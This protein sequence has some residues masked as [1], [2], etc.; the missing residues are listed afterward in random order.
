M[1]AKVRIGIDVGGTFT[2]AV[3]IDNTTH[4]ILAKTKI[5][6]THHEEKGVAAGI[7]RAIEKVLSENRIDPEDVVFIAHGTTQATNALLEG[8]VARV[9][10]IGMGKG[11]G[12]EGM[13]AQKETQIG[14]IELAP[15]KLLHTSQTFLDSGVCTDEDI[16]AAVETVKQAG[17]EVVVASEAYSVDDPA[18]EQRVIDIAVEHGMLATGGH[19]I[20]QLYGLL[21]RTRTASV[22]AALIPK[23]METADMTQ[24]SVQEASIHQP[25]MIMRCDGGVM[26]VAEVRKR[27]ILTML[28]GLAAGV[29]GALMYEKVTDGI[30]IEVGGTSVDISAIRDGRVMIKNAEVGG[31]KLYL[32]SLDVR[33]LGVAGGSMIV[34]R[35]GAIAD[36]G[37]RSAHIADLEYEVFSA[38]AVMAGAE[39]E[40]IAPR[41]EDAAD[42]AAVRCAGGKRRALTL[43]GAANLLG[44]V[45]EG[46]YAHG[47]REAARLAWQPLADRLGIT[48]E[49]ACRQAM[50]IACGKVAEVVEALITDYELNRNLICI[51]G[52]GG[53][54]AV[55]APSLGEKLGIR[56]R[57]ARNAPYI[58]TIGVAMAMVME[59]LERNVVHPTADDIK[60]LRH[61]ITEMIVKAGANPDTVEITV[62]IDGQRNILRGVATG[63]TE[64]RT[65]NLN[66]QDKTLEELA[67]IVGESAGVSPDQ[68]MH[69]AQAGGWHA[70]SAFSVTKTFFGLLKKK[71]TVIRVVDSL[72]VIRLQKDNASVLSVKKGELAHKLPAFIDEMTI[73]NDGG[74]ILPR[75]FMYFR[76]K[77]VDLS[78]VMEKE[79]LLP[80]ANLELEFVDDSEPILMVAVRS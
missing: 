32:T 35:N 13:R 49:S 57:I 55:L 60:K 9:G 7:I 44:Y 31:H 77:A 62:E 40:L 79:Q 6:T 2:D 33:T 65:K 10:I 30:F 53:S 3:V 43:A 78:G 61:D 12:L 59:R 39:L 26:S 52:G 23:M 67:G 63:A 27:P 56:H 68:V 29:A 74:A 71:R 58:S 48:V 1:G 22:N 80:L 15:G 20:S 51:V 46:D 18:N 36:V 70:F 54:A 34:V 11:K 5:P 50:D 72:G 21:A 47:S 75:C 16:A 69:L 17:A 64:L 24:R 73:Y 38:P 4:E 45:P 76:Q 14:S 66:E 19:E 25:L 28:S 37:P 41:P 42:Y 8:D